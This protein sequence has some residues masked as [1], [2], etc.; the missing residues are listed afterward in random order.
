M[1]LFNASGNEPAKH[2]PREIGRKPGKSG[3]WLY[4]GS[5]KYGK[6]IARYSKS[7]IMLQSGKN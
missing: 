3:S 7:W 4:L 5:L 1:L 2:M 6:N